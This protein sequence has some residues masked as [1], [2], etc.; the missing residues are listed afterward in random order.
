MQKQ[1]NQ[2]LNFSEKMANQVNIIL[3][4]NVPKIAD[5]RRLKTSEGKVHD[6]D[7]HFAID[8]II[9]KESGI[10]FTFQ[11]KIRRS[12]FKAYDDFTIEYYS[13]VDNKTKGEFFHLCAD[14]YLHGYSSEDEN[15]ISTLRIIDIVKL[16][17]YIEKN[18][19]QL[20]EKNLRQNNRHS[21]ANFLTIN[22]KDLE[23]A[24]VVIKK[25]SIEPPKP[26]NKKFKR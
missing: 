13:N 11:E 15:S 24:N 22:F 26:K 12:K 1:W 20:L 8:G 19:T 23:N 10:I 21:R 3:K 6:L 17:R 4:N 5:I 14:F 2:D 16:K 18:L 7:I 9:E 25:I